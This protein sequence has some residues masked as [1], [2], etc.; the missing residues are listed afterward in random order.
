[1]PLG[2]VPT[3]TRGSRGSG[4]ALVVS[5]LAG[6]AAAPA[7]AGACATAIDETANVEAAT[8]SMSA[9]RHEYA[10]MASSWGKRIR[11]PVEYVE[12]REPNSRHSERSRAAPC[13][14]S[15]RS[16]AGAEARNRDH[17]GRGPSPSA[18]PNDRR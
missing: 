2:S 3:T 7:P 12:E 11:V 1:M 8:A 5:M 4:V 10:G 9:R 18:A 16:A 13:C 15:E 6:A 17:P 14:H